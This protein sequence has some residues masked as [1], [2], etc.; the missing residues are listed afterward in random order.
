MHRDEFE[1][2][3]HKRSNA[4]STFHSI[5]RKFGDNIKSK[6]CVAQENELLC[7]VVCYNLTVLIKSM[8]EMGITPD[9]YS[10][11]VKEALLKN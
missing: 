11:N 2:H 3:Y 1:K 4:E 10:V 9:F 5:K 6:N 7:K 8:I